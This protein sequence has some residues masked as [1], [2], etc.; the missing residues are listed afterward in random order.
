MQKESGARRR[1]FFRF[2]YLNSSQ[3]LE[4]LRSYL[5]VLNNLNGVLM[6]AGILAALFLTALVTAT[7]SSESYS[8]DKKHFLHN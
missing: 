5:N 6:A 2:L 4:S 7:H 3:G 8:Y 1:F